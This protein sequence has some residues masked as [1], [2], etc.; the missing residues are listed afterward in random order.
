MWNLM[1]LKVHCLSYFVMVRAYMHAML[2]YNVIRPDTKLHWSISLHM[3]SI[4]S[5][6]NEDTKQVQSRNC[7]SHSMKRYIP[8]NQAFIFRK[9]FIIHLLNP[10]FIDTITTVA[11]ASRRRASL[12]K[13]FQMQN[14]TEKLNFINATIVTQTKTFSICTEMVI[15]N[16]WSEEI[17][18]PYI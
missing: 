16:S 15:Q 7:N 9:V 5:I 14:L 18:H 8:Y 10:K 1:L 12:C 17:S 3:C 4:L 11:D 13:H 2:Q 6:Y